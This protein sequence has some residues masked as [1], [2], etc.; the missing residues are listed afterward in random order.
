MASDVVDALEAV[1]VQEQH[2][3]ARLRR[4]LDPGQGLVEAVVE[5]GP[6]RKAREL[7]VER[8]VLQ[9]PLGMLPLRDVLGDAQVAGN[10]PG[11]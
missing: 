7:I 11:F 10:L 3:K 2:R 8:T 6:V 9:L 5:E 4:A 1:Q